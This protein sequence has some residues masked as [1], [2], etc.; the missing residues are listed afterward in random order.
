M[1]GV[2]VTSRT[3][4]RAEL[5]LDDVAATTNATTTVEIAMP[6]HDLELALWPLDSKARVSRSDAQQTKHLFSGGIILP[7]VLVKAF[8]RDSSTGIRKESATT[9]NSQP[10]LPPQR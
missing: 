5:W 8:R 6:C 2:N 3:Q 10:E 1:A 9:A 4:M 7:L